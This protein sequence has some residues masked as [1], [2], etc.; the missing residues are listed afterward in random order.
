[1][2]YVSNA[3][4]ECT[5]GHTVKL[6][7]C[8]FDIANLCFPISI[9]VKL[10]P[11]DDFRITLLFGETV[12]QKYAAV[13]I[14]RKPYADRHF[15]F[16]GILFKASRSKFANE[17][18]TKQLRSGRIGQSNF[19]AVNDIYVS[20]TLFAE[21]NLGRKSYLEHQKPASKNS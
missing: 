17:F 13:V 2:K 9:I 14:I 16:R 1:V 21:K 11:I 8:G 19:L 3:P 5:P 10:N 12:L 6:V 7:E 4:A 20:E 18:G 15:D